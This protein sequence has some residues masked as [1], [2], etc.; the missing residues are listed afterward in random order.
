[1]SVLSDAELR[2]IVRRAIFKPAGITTKDFLPEL[3]EAEML[4]EFLYDDSDTL[5]DNSSM[6]MLG[7][8]AAVAGYTAYQAYRENPQVFKD[9]LKEALKP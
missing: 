4:R 9:M 3:G 2:R 8:A 1:M 7:M 6:A 5:A